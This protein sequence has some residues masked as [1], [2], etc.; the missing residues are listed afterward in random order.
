MKK[1][2]NKHNIAGLTFEQKIEFLKNLKGGHT[3]VIARMSGSY[4]NTGTF[5][6]YVREISKETGFVIGTNPR[7]PYFYQIKYS[8]QTNENLLIIGRRG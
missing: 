8:L 6:N 1:N 5:L 7:I 4:M 2:G 3:A